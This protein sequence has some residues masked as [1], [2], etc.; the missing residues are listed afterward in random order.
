MK[1][2]LFIEPASTWRSRQ[3]IDVY[4]SVFEK[5][6]LYDWHKEQASTH[7]SLFGNRSVVAQG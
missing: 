5:V 2:K 3:P 7:F 6:W 1:N 4:V